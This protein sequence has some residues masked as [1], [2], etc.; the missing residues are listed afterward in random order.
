MNNTASV[1]ILIF[2]ALTFIMS[3]HE[4][5]F[6]WNDTMAWMKPHFSKTYLKNYVPH[7]TLLLVL[8]EVT[9][10]ILSIVGIVQLYVTGDRI[11]GY[12]GA[13]SSCICLLFMLFG[14]RLVKDFDG[15]R[16]IAIY[17]IVAV[18]GV[19]LLGS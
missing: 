2:L 16:T 11:F 5:I 4:K 19:W 3:A 6:H 12:Y 13:V 17:F 10:G 1:L 7:A 9:T 14:Q 15:A 8:L 18:F